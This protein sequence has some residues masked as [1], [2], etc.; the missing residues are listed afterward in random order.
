MAA[1]DF[2]AFERRFRRRMRMQASI[3]ANI[4]ATAPPTA[5]PMIAPNDALL[6]SVRDVPAAAG[7][8]DCE[9]GVEKIPEEVE[10]DDDGI[11]TL[12]PSAGDE[13]KDAAARSA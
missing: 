1:A 5:P 13:F 2:A 11:K 8:V 4:S 10:L 6:E 3:T 12:M 9:D 7:A